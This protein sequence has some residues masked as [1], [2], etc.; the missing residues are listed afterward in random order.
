VLLAVPAHLAL[1]LAWPAARRR[2]G[3]VL[4]GI[5]LFVWARAFGVYVDHPAGA[6]VVLGLGIVG[7]Q[8]AA[9]AGSDETGSAFARSF[10]ALAFA[11][12]WWI[13]AVTAL[14]DGWRDALLPG[15]LA[16]A[17]GWIGVQAGARYRAAGHLVVRVWAW[18]ALLVVGLAA[19]P[20]SEWHGV[21]AL[22]AGTA[23]LLASVR[24]DVSLWWWEGSAWIVVGSLLLARGDAPTAGLCAVGALFALRYVVRARPMDLV[25]AALALD[26]ALL[27][28]LSTARV[29]EPLAYVAPVG[30]SVLLV[31]QRLRATLDPRWIAVLR[32]G[33][34]GSI[35][36]TAFAT[37]LDDPRR[38]LAMVTACL[39]SVGAGALLRVQPLTFLGAGFLAATLGVNAI[40]YGLAHSGFWAV[41][42]T[43]LG[44]A[45]LLAMVVVTVGGRRRPIWPA[46]GDRYR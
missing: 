12:T 11:A 44:L 41:S 17:A 45:V 10:A 7:L 19:M 43:A 32:Y 20:S 42:L 39:V 15:A 25:A 4:V 38:T 3:P 1:W 33:A 2:W 8:V 14:D 24:R 23:L 18:A 26:V 16:L 34:A 21:V 13:V 22:V 31:A 46:P 29:T 9:R 36:V 30:L 27:V 5:A 35:H 6:V 28:E 40:R 37:F